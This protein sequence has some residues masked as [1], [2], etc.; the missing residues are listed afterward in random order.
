MA[1]KRWRR[2]FSLAT[3]LTFF[4]SLATI[5]SFFAFAWIMIHSVKV[6]FAEQDINDLQE[7]STTL[8]R[9]INQ[10]NE[11]ESRR[12]E[13]LKNVVAGYSNVIISLVD[14]NQKAI[15]HSPNAPDL[16]QFIASA[17][18]DKNAHA[19]DVFII[20]GPTL[21]TSRHIHGQKTSSNWRMIRLPVG[22]LADGKP[23]YTLYLALSIDF[24]LHYINDLKNKL[25]MTA[26]LISIMIVFI[27]LFAVYKG[28]EPIRNVSRRIQNITS[29][30]LDVRLDPQAVPIE[31]E[32][33]VSSFNHMLE[34]I[35]DVFKRQSNFSAD[36]AHEIRTPIT[37][38]VT[39]TEIALSQTRTQKEL[40][41]VL[42]SNLEEFGRMSKMVSDMLFL[43]QADNNQLIP[44]KKAL[45]LADEVGKVF[46]FF[47]AWAEEREV[48]LRFEGR[49]C[50]VSGDPL[51]LRRAMSNL[52]SNA[53]RYTPK[54]E[55]VTVRVKEADGL[56]QIVVENPG[57][58][59]P[60][61]HLPRLFDRFYRVDPS[62]QRKGEGS[63]IGL[64]IVKS[65]VIAHH[66][67]VSVTSD[68]YFTRFILTLPK[69]AM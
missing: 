15:F 63:G 24:H 6:H 60:P 28:H 42:Y 39:Q 67:K 1:S 48:G 7:I 40:E 4:I 14:S 22:K 54:G 68:P 35:E 43:A 65:I 12:L 57:P 50:W 3:R 33:L 29:K 59:I 45:N 17:R 5:A 13:T 56:V 34:R 10:P 21:Q 44:E 9:I 31:L 55:S 69:H 32:Q 8:E 61:H 26:S 20:S 2:P 41:D 36:I 19:S 25:I 16:R 62:R 66:G 58:P 30:D 46:D 37:N 27:V 11:P 53:M 51:M 47:E 64:A 18:P 38:L 49:A 23:A 52:L